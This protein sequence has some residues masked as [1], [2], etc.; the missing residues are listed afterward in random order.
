MKRICVVFFLLN[1]F[2]N[3]SL[4]GQTLVDQIKNAYNSLDTVSYVEELI[5]S[6]R[7]NLE[8]VQKE[9]ELE[10]F[11]YMSLDSIQKKNILDS[12]NNICQKRIES[13]NE[14]RLDKYKIRRKSIEEY[15]KDFSDKVKFGKP[16]YVLNLVTDEGSNLHPDTNKLA[17]NLFYFDNKRPESYIFV[18]EDFVEWSKCWFDVGDY[19][20]IKS[21]ILRKIIKKHPHYLLLCYNHYGEKNCNM[22]GFLYNV[23]ERWYYYQICPPKNFELDF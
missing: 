12:L 11:D 16:V 21:K 6:Y 18:N 1:I 8:K 4:C 15:V 14:F 22:D 7:K 10:G 5:L 9:Y 17:F 20:K 3:S 2:S 23:G 19:S 13:L